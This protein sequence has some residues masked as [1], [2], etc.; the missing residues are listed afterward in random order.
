MSEVRAR[1]ALATAC[2]LVILT[3]L[4]AM[5]THLLGQPPP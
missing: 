2:G 1:Y 5:L 4:L 3:V